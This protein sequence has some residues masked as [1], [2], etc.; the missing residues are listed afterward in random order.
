VLKAAT[1]TT[2]LDERK[3]KILKAIIQDYLET[4]EPVGSSNLLKRFR[5][6]VS[7]ATIRNEMAALEEKGY[8]KQ[9]HTSA[10][11]IPSDKGYRYYVDHLMKVKSLSQKDEETIQNIYKKRMADLE[12]LVHETLETVS[13]LTH[14]ATIMRVSKG[15]REERVYHRGISNIATLPEFSNVDHLKHILKIFD[16]EKLLTSMLK[17]YS[18]KDG[19]SITIG[20]ENK[21]RAVRD[22]SVLVAPCT[23]REGEFASIGIIG[24]TRMFYNR[25]VSVIEQITQQLSGFMSLSEMGGL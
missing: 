22:Y 8:I 1:V 5:L 16:E 23:T 2:E 13:S 3:Q 10:G 19:V 7:P 18:H 4:A 15:G 25:S 6:G 21:Y 11:R 17:E 20:S 12:S 9:P 24:P 14:Y